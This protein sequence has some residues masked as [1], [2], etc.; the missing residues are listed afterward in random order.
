M[1]TFFLLYIHIM[2][3]PQWCR[4]KIETTTTIIVFLKTILEKLK[5]KFSLSFHTIQVQFRVQP[6]SRSNLD[7][8]PIWAI[9]KIPTFRC[10]RNYGNSDFNLRRSINQCPNPLWASKVTQK[11]DWKHGYQAGYQARS[12]YILVL[13]ILGQA[14]GWKLMHLC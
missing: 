13:A 2:I 8:L 7:I 6:H 14:G 11:M 1:W 4:Q 3:F 5:Q 10:L 9:I 12:W